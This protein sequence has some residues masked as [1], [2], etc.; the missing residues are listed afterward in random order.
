MPLMDGFEATKAIRETDKCIPIIALTA[1]TYQDHYKKC[2]DS[3]MN[4]VLYKPFKAKQLYEMIYQY[5]K[6]N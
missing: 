6:T 5:T 4:D 3:T 2:I 1:N